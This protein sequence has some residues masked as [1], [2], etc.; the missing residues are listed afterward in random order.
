MKTGNVFAFHYQPTDMSHGLEA[1]DI[2]QY[3]TDLHRN[4]HF[5][6]TQNRFTPEYTYLY[7]TKQI[8]TGIYIYIYISFYI[9]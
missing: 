8:Y 5:Y 4:I 2:S 7:N 1:N 3:K 9:S 6:L